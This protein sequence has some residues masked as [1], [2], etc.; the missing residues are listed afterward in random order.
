[1]D[2]VES[3]AAAGAAASKIAALLSKDYIPLDPYVARIQ[4]DK[5]TGCEACIPECAYTGA[6]F[7]NEGTKKAQV[8]AA[9]CKGCGACVAVCKPRALDLAGWSIDQMDAMVDA[10]VAEVSV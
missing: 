10:M 1:M 7:M 6:L 5:C 8:N 3:A 2:L 9:L 4:E